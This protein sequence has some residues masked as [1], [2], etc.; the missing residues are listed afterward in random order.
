VQLITLRCGDIVVLHDHKL[1]SSLWQLLTSARV[2]KN[3]AAIH[4]NVN[5]ITYY[6]LMYK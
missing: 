1:Y 4:C 3:A 2:D 6:C 5:Y